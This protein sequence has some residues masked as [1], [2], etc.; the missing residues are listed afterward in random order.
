MYKPHIQ[1]CDFIC[2]APKKVVLI[3]KAARAANLAL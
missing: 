3:W 1:A 2:A